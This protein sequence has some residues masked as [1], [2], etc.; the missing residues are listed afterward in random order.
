MTTSAARPLTF[1][2]FSNEHSEN[3][4]SHFGPLRDHDPVYY[5]EGG[6]AWIVTRYQDVADLLKDP[7]FTMDQRA[8]KHYVDLDGMHPPDL[9]AIRDNHLFQ[10]SP[11]DHARVRK[12]AGPSFAPST[13]ARLEGKVQDLVDALIAEAGFGARDTVD[14]AREF[15]GP[16]PIR[17]LGVILGIPQEHEDVFRRWGAGLMKIAF[18]FYTPEELQEALAVVPTGCEVVRSLIEE[19][20]SRPCDDLLSFLVN[21]H[22]QGQRLSSNELLALLAALITAGTDS[23]A[24]LISYA[25]Y[26]LLTHPDELALVR[27]DPGRI[28]NALEEVLRYDNFS[29]L[30]TMRFALEDVTLRGKTIARGDMVVAA[31]GGAMYDRDVWPDAD[32]FDVSRDPGRNLSFGRGPHFCIGAHLARLEGTVAVRT[33]LQRFPDMRLSSKPVISPHPLLRP[34]QSLEVALC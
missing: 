16:L 28:P 27:A 2:P 17:A 21:A 19:R 24:F 23:T 13:I 29:R 31:I 34:I 22:D 5:W 20:R 4:E 26:N 7:R 14:L 3:P 10:L 9:I 1:D 8:W 25:I 32:R 33:L 11:A 15:S 12:L 6:N 30:G 18:P